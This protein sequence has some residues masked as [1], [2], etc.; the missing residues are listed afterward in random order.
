MN[1][2]MRRALSAAFCIWGVLLADVC[3]AHA[4]F[5]DITLPDG[6]ALTPLASGPG[7][8][9]DDLAT[10]VNTDITATSVTAGGMAGGF[11]PNLALAPDLQQQVSSTDGL[12]LDNGAISGR[13]PTLWPGYSNASYGQSYADGSPEGNMLTT[14][15]TLQGTLQASADQ[16]NSQTAEINRLEALETENAD[17]TGLF[18]LLEIGNE[19]AIFVTEEEMKLRN[20]TNAQ[21]NALVVAESNRQNKRAQDELLSL[22][23]MTQIAH[24][25]LTQS[26]IIEPVL[27]DP[28]PY[29][30]CGLCQT[31]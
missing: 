18:Q 16:Q 25:D 24:W 9:V 22:G 5:P 31:E 23:V 21:L 28:P 7:T 4:Q 2:V 11:D 17:A 8:P 26:P 3:C 29:T 13:Y 20:S 27:P 19:A 6:H 1:I 12:P 15:G 30:T 14:L 10:N